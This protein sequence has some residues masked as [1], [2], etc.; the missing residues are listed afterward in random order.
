MLVRGIRGREIPTLRRTLQEQRPREAPEGHGNSLA[1]RGM[2]SGGD[3]VAPEGWSCGGGRPD[4][5]R[6]PFAEWICFGRSVV[7]SKMRACVEA[8]GD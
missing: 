7:G 8:I 4:V 3:S 1:R 2:E 5:G 6:L